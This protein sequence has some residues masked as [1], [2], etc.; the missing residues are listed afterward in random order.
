MLLSFFY[1]KLFIC[2][3]DVKR[4]KFFRHFFSHQGSVINPVCSLQQ[5][6]IPTSILQHSK[7]QS[8]TKT[9]IS[10][11]AWIIP[12]LI[13][14]HTCSFFGKLAVLCF[15]EAP[16]LRF[17]LFLITDEL[18]VNQ[19]SV[20]FCHICGIAF[21]YFSFLFVRNIIYLANKIH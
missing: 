2:P 10:K 19:A 6:K 1:F 12:A 3:P 18:P 17:T 7:T 8:C 13:H 21:I 16:V 20:K 4:P 15:L 9:D 14:T 5:L 11:T